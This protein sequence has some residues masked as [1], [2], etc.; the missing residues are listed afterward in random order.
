M[1]DDGDEE[2]NGQCNINAS[3]PST[4]KPVSSDIALI[5][6]HDTG[7]KLET[8]ERLKLNHDP[9]VIIQTEPTKE[10]RIQYQDKSYCSPIDD[11]DFS[12]IESS[13]DDKR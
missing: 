13:I 9:I 2:I 5:F 6:S 4:N 1:N 11:L 10:V 7:D 8:S 3:V 12:S